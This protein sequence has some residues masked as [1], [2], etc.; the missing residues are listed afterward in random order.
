MNIIFFSIYF[1]MLFDDLMTIF[2]NITFPAHVFRLLLKG[3]KV[4]N[5]FCFPFFLSFLTKCI[6]SQEQSIGA[7]LTLIYQLFSSP[8]K[9]RRA[10]RF[11]SI[12]IFKAFF[13]K[14]VLKIGANYNFKATAPF[15]ILN[16]ISVLNLRG[17]AG[18]LFSN[19]LV[20]FF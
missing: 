3:E 5:F 4:L 6:I 2:Q 13:L 12:K 7:K 20:F 10:L 16:T 19:L 15:E 8:S 9:R 14:N 1:K 17:N 18:K 11:Y